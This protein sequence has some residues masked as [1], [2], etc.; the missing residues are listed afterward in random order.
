MIGGFFIYP[1]EDRVIANSRGGGRRLDQPAK[2]VGDTS[3]RKVIAMTSYKDL[4]NIVRKLLPNAEVCRDDCDQIVIYTGI[5]KSDEDPA[6]R[7]F[8]TD[9]NKIPLISDGGFVVRYWFDNGYGAS[10]VWHRNSYGSREG[11]FELAVLRGS[12]GDWFFDNSTDITGDV[13]GWLDFHQV[14]DHLDR[15]KSL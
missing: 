8:A 4:K 1:R 9:N 2:V 12:E 11:K 3:T 7:V 6:A 15:I 13:I 10:V 5:T 14:A